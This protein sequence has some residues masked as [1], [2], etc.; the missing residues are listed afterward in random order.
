MFV[1]IVVVV[2]VVVVVVVCFIVVVGVVVVVVV[3][4]AAVI[5]VVMVVVM[6]V[7]VLVVA[8]PLL[9]LLLRLS[10]SFFLIFSEMWNCWRWVTVIAIE[11]AKKS[12]EQPLSKQN[13][14]NKNKTGRRK[15]LAKQNNETS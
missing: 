1:V 11:Q 5:I 10:P 7:A 2:L 15:A 4:I 3:M 6:V 12:Y 14:K 13:N 8:V 9:L